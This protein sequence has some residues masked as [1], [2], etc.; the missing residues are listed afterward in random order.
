VIFSHIPI[1]VYYVW[2]VATQQLADTM[3]YVYGVV[4]CVIGAIVMILLPIR[5]MS[6]RES[7]Y[8]FPEAMFYGFAREKLERIRRT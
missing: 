6:S 5:L 4:F 3:D 1:G 2:Y 8:A 7:K